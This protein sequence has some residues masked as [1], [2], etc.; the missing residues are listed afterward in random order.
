MEYIHSKGYIHKDV[1]GSNILFCRSSR[2][3]GSSA[4][5]PGDRVF[6]VDFGLCSKFRPGGLHKPYSPDRRWAHEGTLEYTSRDCHL[7]CFSRRGDLEVTMY[8]LVEWMGGRLPWEDWQDVKP[9]VIQEAKVKAFQNVNKFL[10]NCFSNQYEGEVP[11]FLT[12]M[13]GRVANMRFDEAPDYDGLKQ[14]M[15]DEIERVE[16]IPK[17]L[18]SEEEDAEV[19]LSVQMT[20][21]MTPVHMGKENREPSGVTVSDEGKKVNPRSGQKKKRKF[22]RAGRRIGRARNRRGTKKF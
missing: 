3:H 17:S 7:G 12:E 21:G 11:K 19:T 20:R 10:S 6:L 8:N 4:P 16:A 13:F 22:V 14:I 2:R 9:S 1:K 15:S 5:A 18:S